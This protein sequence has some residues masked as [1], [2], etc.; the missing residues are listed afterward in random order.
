MTASRSGHQ[1]GRDTR[2]SCLCVTTGI[3]RELEEGAE[4]EM[5]E[6]IAL[7]FQLAWRMMDTVCKLKLVHSLQFALR[8]DLLLTSVL[9][10]VMF[11][12]TV[13]V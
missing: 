11:Q 13:C 5:F 8:A 9:F 4:T 1:I 2:R 12:I 7:I 6:V 3:I 10:G